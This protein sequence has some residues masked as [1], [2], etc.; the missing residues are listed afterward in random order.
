MK[1][2]AFAL[3]SIL[4]GSLAMQEASAQPAYTDR[5]ENVSMASMAGAG[6]LGGAG[7]GAEGNYSRHGD[8]AYA[9]RHL[10]YT[11]HMRTSAPPPMDP[12]R[13]I[14]E[15]DCTLPFDAF[16]GNLLCR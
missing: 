7:G 4:L 12:N 13:V 1:T 14:N 6:G 10:S 3:S 5:R 9:N 16:K 15:V 11:R 2:L 8:A